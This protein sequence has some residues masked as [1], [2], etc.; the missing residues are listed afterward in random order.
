MQTTIDTNAGGITT[1]DPTH[2]SITFIA[3]FDGTTPTIVLRIP[4][5]SPRTLTSNA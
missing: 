1:V 5:Q 2:A 4:N 3:S